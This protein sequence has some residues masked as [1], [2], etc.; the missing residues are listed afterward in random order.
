[1]LWGVLALLASVLCLGMNAFFVAA[2]FALVK[3]RITQLDRA[4]RRG[5]KRAIAA[6]EVLQRLD[7]YLSV[8]QFGIT[9]ASLGLGWIGE[10]ALTHL[11]DAVALAVAGRPLGP[12]GHVLV[13]V[14]GLALLTFLH[15]LLGEL[16]PKFVAI[17][18]SEATVLN[19]AIL[20]RT[21][22]TVFAPVL[23]I[24][25]KAQRA[26]LR[27]IQIDPD[28][29]H[30]GALSED[31][32]IGVLAASAARNET[33]KDKQRII[34]RILR[35]TRRP[36]RQMM[37][38]RVDVVWLPI[39]STIEEAIE[40]LKK[41]QFS[42][43]P[44]AKGS[45]DQVVGYLYAKDL[46]LAEAEPRRRTLRS[47]QR[48]VLFVPEERDGLSALRDMQAH[49]VPIAIVVDEYGGTSGI[50][51]LEDLVEEIVGEIRDEL[52]V[53]P[54]RVVRMEQANEWDVDARATVDELRDA[55]VPIE[56]EEVIFGEPVGTLVYSRLGHI[57][58]VG[59]VVRLAKDVVAE[60]AATSRRRIE[61]VRVRVQAEQVSAG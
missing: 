16:V 19:S 1:M 46:L 37:V 8:T 43:V 21:V 20:L 29:V 9:V 3:V 38:P 24:L 18:H 41:H 13:D 11:A 56:E 40:V 47:L 50:V 54:A 34:E 15:L 33:A 60:V 23:W 26:V 10:P 31:E 2:E 22:N 39:D 12:A 51:T 59:D 45:L 53:E 25:E 30:E 57:P 17:Q 32:L 49:W 61:R 36:V 52:D 5:D 42:R 44:L 6:R 4:V 27:A 35:L 7:R 14:G 58:R 48:P 28:V 55:G